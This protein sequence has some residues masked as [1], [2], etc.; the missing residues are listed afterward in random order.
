MTS[1]KLTPES[2]LPHLRHLKGCYCGNRTTMQ[3]G[4]QERGPCPIP[5]TSDPGHA[6]SPSPLASYHCH[7]FGAGIPYTL[8]PPTLSILGHIQYGRIPGPTLLRGP[9][10]TAA[11]F[12]L[13]GGPQH[14]EGKKTGYFPPTCPQGSELCPAH[15]A[16]AFSLSAK[17]RFS[18]FNLYPLPLRDKTLALLVLRFQNKSWD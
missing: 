18:T 12:G 15:P 13:R 16:K 14:G 4:V 10:S 1:D 7:M 5:F 11:S 9:F 6:L 8:P 17:K 3:A 2:R